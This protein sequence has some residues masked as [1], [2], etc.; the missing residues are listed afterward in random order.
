VTDRAY[1]V[2]LATTI[3]QVDP[4]EW[5]SL[6]GGRSFVNHR[7][8]RLREA[9]YAR[10]DPTYLQLRRRGRLEAAV[11][12][13]RPLRFM[14]PL[15]I[16]NPALRA[17][18]GRLAAHWRPLRCGAFDSCQPALLTRL[19]CDPDPLAAALLE[20]VRE[21][22]AERQAPA[23][24]MVNLGPRD[25]AW[26]ALQAAGYQAVRLRPNTYLDLPWSTVE[27]YRRSLPRRKRKELERHRRRAWDQGVSWD[28]HQVSPETEPTLR[29]LV[30]NVFER[31]NAQD[32]HVPDLF[33]R[34][35]GVLGDDFRLLVARQQEHPIGCMTLLRCGG[36]LTVEWLGLDYSRSRNTHTYHCLL[37]ESVAQ[38]I[39][40]GVRRVWFGDTVYELKRDV[41]ATLE[42]RYAAVALPNP[43]LN[44]MLGPALTLIGLP[45]AR[46]SRLEH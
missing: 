3:E 4:A 32:P 40:M 21:L 11:I 14:F 5:D 42:N 43:R 15:S 20:A 29:K 37:S 30:R 17:V 45:L 34:V 39:E 6:C 38:A 12:C 25:A 24:S 33:T 31:H 36:E 46:P 28:T 8:Q 16:P 27:C 9:V 18:W 22:A 26:P 1:T 35:K 10:Y 41:G 7:W 13:L 44:R 19:G 2:E 23:I